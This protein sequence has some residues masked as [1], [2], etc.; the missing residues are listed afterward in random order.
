MRGRDLVGILAAV[1]AL[2][3]LAACRQI[4][5]VGGQYKGTPHNTDI[6]III[7]QSCGVL[8]NKTGIGFSKQHVFWHVRNK[9]ATY[10][11]KDVQIQFTNNHGSSQPPIDGCP[12]ACKGTIGNGALDLD[13]TVGDK[14]KGTYTYTLTIGGT[15]IDPDL[16][17]DP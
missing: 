10:D 6:I 1:A 12:D 3:A 11:G 15:P 8:M 16:E 5:F 17:I 13:L 7:D 2:V 9:C 4:G 14:R